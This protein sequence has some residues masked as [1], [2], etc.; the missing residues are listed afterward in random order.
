MQTEVSYS[1]G[2]RVMPETRLT[3]FPVTRG[4]R[5]LGLHRRPMV[6]YFSY[7]LQLEYLS[8][9]T[10]LYNLMFYDGQLRRSFEVF[11][12]GASEVPVNN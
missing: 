3:D 11:R 6:D 12:Y 2:K 9:I 5:F 1:E 4:L 8:F 7:L 10:F